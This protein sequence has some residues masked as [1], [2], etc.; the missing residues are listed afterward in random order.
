MVYQ[1]RLKRTSLQD[2]EINWNVLLGLGLVCT[3]HSPV[4]TPFDG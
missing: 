1:A 3:Q 4:W 2:L